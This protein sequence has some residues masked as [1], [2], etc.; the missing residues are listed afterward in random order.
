MSNHER[1]YEGTLHWPL[2]H[3]LGGYTCR[4]P[5]N[6]PL[7]PWGLS[8]DD[9]KL[10]RNMCGALLSGSDFTTLDEIKDKIEEHM[11]TAHREEV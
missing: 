11:R 4:A 1:V 2:Y 6:E 8:D 7:P 3:Q 5:M 10:P 9:P